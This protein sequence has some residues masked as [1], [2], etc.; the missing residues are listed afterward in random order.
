M[1]DCDC[2]GTKVGWNILVKAAAGAPPALSTVS[3][4]CWGRPRQNDPRMSVGSLQRKCTS[5][6]GWEF[7]ISANPKATDNEHNPIQQK[8]PLKQVRRAPGDSF[9]TDPP[10][11]A[12]VH[13]AKPQVCKVTRGPRGRQVPRGGAEGDQ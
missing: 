8:Q 3:S 2:P 13:C 9:Q 6:S 1:S 4:H 5:Q 12:W 11:V 10:L 7:F